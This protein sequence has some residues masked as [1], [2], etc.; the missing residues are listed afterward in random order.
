MKMQA[1][2]QSELHNKKS[3]NM[4]KR[5]TEII[6]IETETVTLSRGKATGRAVASGN[7]QTLNNKQ[8]S[9]S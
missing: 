6:L 2:D 8:S 3:D 4:Y 5:K 1:K 9:L 7:T